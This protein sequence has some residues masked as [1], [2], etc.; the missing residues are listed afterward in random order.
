M[1]LPYQILSEYETNW[2]TNNR[3]LR[4]GNRYISGLEL[5]ETYFFLGGIFGITVITLVWRNLATAIIGSVLSI[6]LGLYVP[7]LLFILTFNLF[8]LFTLDSNDLG[9]G[10]YIGALAILYFI[11]I[12]FIN[13]VQTARNR[14][15]N[16]RSAVVDI[17]DDF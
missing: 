10:F 1:F 9:I 2:R 6:G 15:N 3:I 8:T 16:D 14:K 13:L 17:L 12:Q 5:P 11:V 7:L 4:E